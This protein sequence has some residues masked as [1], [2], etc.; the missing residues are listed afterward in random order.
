MFLY[1][2]RGKWIIFIGNEGMVNNLVCFIAGTIFA[3][4]GLT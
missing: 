3:Q 1:R 2:A 4:T